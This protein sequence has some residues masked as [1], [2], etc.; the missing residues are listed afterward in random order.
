MLEGVLFDYF[1]LR[2]NEMYFPFLFSRLSQRIRSNWLSVIFNIG[3]F[4]Q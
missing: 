2:K 4:S 1:F 3:S